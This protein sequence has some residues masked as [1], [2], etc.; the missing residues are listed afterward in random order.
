MFHG[1]AFAALAVLALAAGLGLGM[2]AV[3]FRD[4]RAARRMDRSRP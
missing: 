2:A 1:A 4:A 3:V